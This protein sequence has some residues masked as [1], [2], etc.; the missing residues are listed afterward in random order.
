MGQS[1]RSVMMPLYVLMA[2]VMAEG[3]VKPREETQRIFDASCLCVVASG[4]GPD[5]DHWCEGSTSEATVQGWDKDTRGS[6]CNRR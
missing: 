6:G 3:Q 5:R 1:K 4:P 2:L